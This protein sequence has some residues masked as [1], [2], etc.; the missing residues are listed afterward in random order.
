MNIFLKVVSPRLYLYTAG[1]V[2]S[3]FPINSMHNKTPELWEYRLIKI[4]FL[5]SRPQILDSFDNGSLWRSR[6]L[7]MEGRFHNISM[8]S[9]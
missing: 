7:K 4:H 2:I 8:E 1:I 3:R 5:P 6:T 9:G